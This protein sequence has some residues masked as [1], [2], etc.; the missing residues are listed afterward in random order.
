MNV[1][2]QKR[3]RLVMPHDLPRYHLSEVSLAEV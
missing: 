1:E 3:G 2:A